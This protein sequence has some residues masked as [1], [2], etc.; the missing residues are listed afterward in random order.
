MARGTA[1]IILFLFFKRVLAF[2]QTGQDPFF[3]DGFQLDD[4]VPPILCTKRR[5]QLAEDEQYAV[6]RGRK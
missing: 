4:Y 5:H 1:A 2:F 3:A 6:Q